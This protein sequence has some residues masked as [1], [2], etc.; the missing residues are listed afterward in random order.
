VTNLTVTD[1]AVTESLSASLSV[2][3]LLDTR[4][5]D[6]ASAALANFG[7]DSIP[8]PRRS[9]LLKLTYSF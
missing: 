9:F 6:P 4:Y 3:N 7:L 1:P 8:Q 2:Y 5:S